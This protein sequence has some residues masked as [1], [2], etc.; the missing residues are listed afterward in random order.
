MNQ[1]LNLLSFAMELVFGRD[2]SVRRTRSQTIRHMIVIAVIAISVITDYYMFKSMYSSTAKYIAI[3]EQQKDY[4]ALRARIQY[5]EMHNQMLEAV[6]ASISPGTVVRAPA[7]PTP[8]P[9][10]PPAPPQLPVH[11]PPPVLAPRDKEVGQDKTQSTI[12]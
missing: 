2:A 10:L 8:P 11:T 9:T 6:I 7:S 4:N 3:R 5:L 12:G 1:I